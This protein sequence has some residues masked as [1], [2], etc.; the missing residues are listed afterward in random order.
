MQRVN[1]LPDEYFIEPSGYG[2]NGFGTQF[3]QTDGK[4][5]KNTNTVYWRSTAADRQFNS[6]STI[7]Y[8]ICLGKFTI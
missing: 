6:S 8:W 7:Y 4:F 5:D 3:N 1:E 2:C